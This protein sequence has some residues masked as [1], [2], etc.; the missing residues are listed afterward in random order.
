MLL[1][2]RNTFAQ[3]KKFGSGGAKAILEKTGGKCWYCGVILTDNSKINSNLP[4]KLKRTMF[5]IDHI[6]PMAKG[7]NR[8]KFSNLVPCCNYCN[9]TKG[10]SSNEYLRMRLLFYKNNWPI[11]TAH[12]YEFLV[13]KGINLDRFGE[14]IFFFEE[15]NLLA[16]EE[17]SGD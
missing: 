12:L 3:K 17:K 2:E 16:L 7:G 1:C 10:C 14:Y 13:S 11:F 9:N 6:I 15:N 8:F 4:D 5:T